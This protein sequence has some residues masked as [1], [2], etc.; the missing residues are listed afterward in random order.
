ME[1]EE[2]EI[3]ERLEA[4]TGRHHIHICMMRSP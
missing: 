2:E 4:G 1:V 3:N